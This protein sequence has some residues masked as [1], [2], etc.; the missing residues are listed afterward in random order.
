MLPTAGPK[1]SPPPDPDPSTALL[2]LGSLTDKCRFYLTHSLALFTWKAYSSAQCCFITF[3]SQDNPLHPSGSALPASEE[4]V[5]SFCTH[6]NFQ[7]RGDHIGTRQESQTNGNY[8]N[9]FNKEAT[10]S[11]C[12]PVDS[13]MTVKTNHLILC[14]TT[15]TKQ[16]GLRPAGQIVV[17][18]RLP[19][20]QYIFNALILKEKEWRQV[21][22]LQQVNVSRRKG[23][24]RDT[25]ECLVS[26]IFRGQSS[27][28][29]GYD[30]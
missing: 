12:T 29:C 11:R 25:F 7:G 26:I 13:D 23:R 16:I 9:I 20:F 3:C 28:G 19:Y 14:L 4:T 21:K 8:Y 5:I 22:Y 24:Q 30:S 2:R 10:D 18:L 15:W 1:R 27:R 6:L 17:L